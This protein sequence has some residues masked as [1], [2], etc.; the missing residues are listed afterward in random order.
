MPVLR[1]K[2]YFFRLEVRLRGE[3][4]F[5]RLEVRLRGETYLGHMLRFAPQTL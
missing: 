1:G 5:F 3:T 4:Y 2:T